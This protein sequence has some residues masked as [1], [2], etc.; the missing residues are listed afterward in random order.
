MNANAMANCWFISPLFP[1]LCT[2][3]GYQSMTSF[4]SLLK[5]VSTHNGG[6]RE[7]KIAW[8]RKTI[9]LNLFQRSIRAALGEREKKFLYLLLEGLGKVPPQSGFA[10][11]KSESHLSP[12]R[13]LSAPF[14]FPHTISVCIALRE[15]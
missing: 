4:F 1:T 8:E 6:E 7:T 11:M 12:R 3:Y 15:K 10:E 5:D 13:E 2:S 9:P 14:I